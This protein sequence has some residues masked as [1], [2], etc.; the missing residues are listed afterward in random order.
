MIIYKKL[1]NATNYNNQWSLTLRLT[2]GV[3]GLLGSFTETQGLFKGVLEEL[4]PQLDKNINEQI[5][6]KILIIL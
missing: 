2:Q 6:N 3:I 5:T 4:R 1:D